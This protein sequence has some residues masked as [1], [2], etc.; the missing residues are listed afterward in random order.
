MLTFII[1][2]IFAII[3][4]IIG[5]WP[6]QDEPVPDMNDYSGICQTDPATWGYY[7]DWCHNHG[8]EEEA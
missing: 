7:T 3:M 4:N 1:G 6:L 5:V 8:F 2:N